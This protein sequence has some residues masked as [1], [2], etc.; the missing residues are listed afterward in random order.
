MGTS[1]VNM[2]PTCLIIHDMLLAGFVSPEMS[3]LQILS[4]LFNGRP[5]TLQ[6]QQQ[7]QVARSR[8]AIL[9]PFLLLPPPSFFP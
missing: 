6:Q 4:A 1:I 7:R 8:T 5:A 3:W 9:Y 2:Q